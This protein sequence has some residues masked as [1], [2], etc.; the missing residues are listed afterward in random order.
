[1]YNYN[2]IIFLY[3]KDN[4]GCA[5]KGDP[6][7]EPGMTMKVAGM[8]MMVAGSAFRVICGVVRG[9]CYGLNA[10]PQAFSL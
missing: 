8:T 6:R 4:G 9:E 2:I 10:H 7:S 5:I 1:M 3:G